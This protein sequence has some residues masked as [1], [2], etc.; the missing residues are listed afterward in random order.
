[1]TK[2]KKDG[3]RFGF[4]GAAYPDLRAFDKDYRLGFALGYAEGS[5]I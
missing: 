3:F 1:M 2:G 4:N 5:A